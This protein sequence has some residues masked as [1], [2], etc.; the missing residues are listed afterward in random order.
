MLTCAIS[1]LVVLGFLLIAYILKNN[2]IL[3]F[4]KIKTPKANTREF[5]LNTLERLGYSPT[6]VKHGYIQFTY[7]NVPMYIEAVEDKKTIRIIHSLHHKVSHFKSSELFHCMIHFLNT[8]S[9]VKI[10]PYEADKAGYS[11]IY[12]CGDILFIKE[13]PDVES[14]LNNTLDLFIDAH[15]ELHKMLQDEELS[16]FQINW[17]KG[18]VKGTC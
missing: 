15:E 2:Q 12:I 9:L 14:F 11:Y 17:T 18:Q 7:K 13:I 1:L 10:I 16:S 8:H 4:F 5:V 6:I 3:T